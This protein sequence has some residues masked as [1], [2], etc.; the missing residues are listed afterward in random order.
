MTL[1]HGVCPHYSLISQEVGLGG[2][3]QTTWLHRTLTTWREVF[4][5][6]VLEGG[7]GVPYT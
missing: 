2:V 7:E 1:N 3:V 6:P 4:E 5:T